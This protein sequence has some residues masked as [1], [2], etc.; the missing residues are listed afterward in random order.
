MFGGFFIFFKPNIFTK[1]IKNY[2]K[3]SVKATRSRADFNT[4]NKQSISN[5][6]K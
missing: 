4:F 1:M 3:L 2:D 6:I 5:T